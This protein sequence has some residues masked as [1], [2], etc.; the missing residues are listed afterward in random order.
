M[1]REKERINTMKNKLTSLIWLLSWTFPL[2]FHFF[3][4][5]SKQLKLHSICQHALCHNFLFQFSLQQQVLWMKFEKT[6]RHF[7]L[8]NDSQFHFVVWQFHFLSSYFLFKTKSIRKF[9]TSKS[10]NI[11]DSLYLLTFHYHYHRYYY[12]SSQ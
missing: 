1:K 7:D 5:I 8:M 6:L 4:K 11:K 3:D 9:K 12:Y 2:Y 10:K